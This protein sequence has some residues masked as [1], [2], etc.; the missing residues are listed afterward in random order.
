[1]EFE[2]LNQKELPEGVDTAIRKGINDILEV[3]KDIDCEAFH[4][5]GPLYM[6]DIL[7]A[8]LSIV[9]TAGYEEE[10]D[11]EINKTFTELLK[12]NMESKR[13]FDKRVKKG[14]E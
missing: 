1:M 2:E 9:L 14:I 8:T 13:A 11:K 6:C 7:L 10:S 12:I 3:L 5:Q 4:L